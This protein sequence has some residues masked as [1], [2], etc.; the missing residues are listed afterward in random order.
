MPAGYV[1]MGEI[2]IV[3]ARASFRNRAGQFVALVEEG[4]IEGIRI[5]ANRAESF[6]QAFA[7][8]KTGELH[9]SIVGQ[10][11]GTSAIVSA[12]A[13][14][15]RYQEFGTGP[16]GALGQF[17]TNRI[18]FAARGPVA[19]SP[20]TRFLQRSQRAASREGEEIL[21]SVLP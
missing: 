13:P 12:T 5:L 19:G 8:F 14:H 18:D 21:A 3:A 17:L 15:A 11:F 7:P 4:L 6:A 9:D 1:S 16:K 20:A 10:A 2:E